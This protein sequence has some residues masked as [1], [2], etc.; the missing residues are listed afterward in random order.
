MPMIDIYAPADL[1]PVDADRQL[2]EALTLAILRAEGVAVPGPFHLNNTA[3]FIHRLPAS[4]IQ[5]PATAAARSVR[6][7]VITPPAALTREG[8]KQLAKEVTEIVA[9]ISGDSTQ[10]SRTWVILHGTAASG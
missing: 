1:F 9:R 10:A 8:Q 5:T 4:A 2:G 3:A 6:V 7:Q